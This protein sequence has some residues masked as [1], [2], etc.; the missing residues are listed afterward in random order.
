MNAGF[1]QPVRTEMAA[2]QAL[3]IDGEHPVI[4]GYIARELWRLQRD[5]E[6]GDHL[7]RA[8]R[9][10]PESLSTRVMVSRGW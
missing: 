6:A 9:L 3:E 4:L 10:V 1:R 5:E 2:V 8:M 7:L